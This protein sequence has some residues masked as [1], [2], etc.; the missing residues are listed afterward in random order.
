MLYQFAYY[1]NIKYLTLVNSRLISTARSS[2]ASSDV[3]LSLLKTST[4]FSSTVTFLSWSVDSNEESDLAKSLWKWIMNCQ[5]F[6]KEICSLKGFLELRKCIIVLILGYKSFQHT[7]YNFVKS[8][9]CSQTN[10]CWSSI[11]SHRKV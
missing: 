1:H 3:S 5:S 4:V 11:I 6:S 7:L 10:V 9:D 8:V 2:M